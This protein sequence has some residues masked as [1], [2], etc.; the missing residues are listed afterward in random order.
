MK[1]RFTKKLY[2]LVAIVALLFVAIRGTAQ[3]G[4]AMNFSKPSLQYITVPHS[5]SINLGASF[6]MEAMVMYAGAS[7]TIVDKGDYDFL[8]S[9]NANDNGSKMG[10]FNPSTGWVYSTGTVRQGVTTHVAVVGSGGSVTFYIDGVASGGGVA[11]SRQDNQPMNIGR[12]Q[13]TACQCNHFNGNM[14]ELRIWNVVRTPAQIQ[15]GMYTTVPSNSAGL[16]AYYKFDEASGNTAVDATA[17]A[18]NGTLVNGP[19]RATSY[20]RYGS[21]G[22]F[23]YTVPQGIGSVYLRA[24]GAGASASGDCNGFSGGGG[25]YSQSKPM[26]V[27]PGQVITMRVGTAGG[28]AAPGEESYV[29]FASTKKLAAY[30][31]VVRYGGAASTVATFPDL[32]FSYKGGDAGN[33]ISYVNGTAGTITGFGGAGASGSPTGA[34]GNGGSPTPFVYTTAGGTAGAEGGN[35]GGGA[36]QLDCAYSFS[37]S[38]AQ[39]GQNV[40]AG[41]GAPYYNNLYGRAVG[42]MIQM[43]MC[44]LGGT[45]GPSHTVPYPAELSADTIRS[46]DGG[47]G[48]SF[49]WQTSANGTSGWTTIAGATAAYYPLPTPN[50]PPN[51]VFYRRLTATC[52]NTSNV[53]MIRT[54]TIANTQLKGKI[55]GTVVSINNTGVDGIPVEAQKTVSLLGSPITHIYRDTTRNGGKFSFKNVFY[56]DA[57]NNDPGTTQF[58]IKAAYAGHIFSPPVLTSLA[59]TGSDFEVTGLKITDSTVYA[60]SGAVT[61]TCNTCDV[62]VSNAIDS[63]KVA[64]VRAGSPVGISYSG[65]NGPGNYGFT[66]T[67]PGDYV[68][69]PSYRNHTFAPPARTVNVTNGS[70]PNNNFSDN[71]TRT[72]TGTLR[73]GNNQV[74]GSAQLVFTDTV[75]GRQPAFTKTVNTAADGSFSVTLPARKY[76]VRVNTFTPAGAGTDITAFELTTFFNQIIKDSMLVDIDTLPRTFNL[77]YHRSP[78]LQIVNLADTTCGTADYVVFRQNKP[79]TFIIN[80]FEGNPSHGFKVATDTARRINLTTNVHLDNVEQTI[81]RAQVNGADTIA[82]PG[83]EPNIIAPFQKNFRLNYIDKYGRPAPQITRK[84]VVLGIKNDP[85]T[86]TTVSPQIPLMIL[87]DPPG[88]QSSSFWE[89]NQTNET[90]MRMY[91]AKSE[92]NGGYLEVKLGTR[93]QL[94]FVYSTEVSIWGTLNF[95]QTVTGRVNDATE[96]ILTTTNS[97]RYESSNSGYIIGNDGD[98]YI[99]AALNLLYAIA[100]EVKYT[101]PCTLG[102]EAKLAI[103]DSGFATEYAY[104]ESHITGTVIPTLQNFAANAPDSAQRFRALNQ[105]H[106]WEQV[107]ANNAANKAKAKFEVNKSFDGADAPITLSTTTTAT[108]SNTIEYAMEIDRNVA[109]ALGFEIAGIGVSGG[110]NVN[111]KMETGKSTTTTTTNSTTMGYTLDDKDDGDY[112]S[113]DVKR[114]PVYNSP[115]FSLKAGTT[116]C[117]AEPPGQNR[118]GAQ[119]RIP[120]PVQNNVPAN[121]AASFQLFL[122][123]VSQSGEAR[124]YKLTMLPASNPH[125]AIVKIG[126][127][128]ATDLFDFPGIPYAQEQLVTITVEKGAGNVYNYEGLK[129]VMSSACGGSTSIGTITANFANPCSGISLGAPANNFIISAANNNLLPVQMTGYTVANLQSIALEHTSAGGSIFVTDTLILAANITNPT[130]TMVNWRTTNLPDG[131]YDLRLRLDCAGGVVYSQRVTGI[132]DRKAPLVFGEPEPMDDSYV[133]GDI[134]SVTYNESINTNSLNGG[135]VKLRKRSDGT[136]I[137]VQVTGYQNKIVVVPVNPIT[138][139]V[140]ENLQLIVNNIADVYGNVQTAADTSLFV[141]GTTVPGT[142]PAALNLTVTRSSMRENV[143]DSLDFRFNIGTSVNYDRLVNYTVS[144]TAIYGTDYTVR[145]PVGQPAATSFNGIQGKIYILAGQV[146]ATLRIKAI[147]DNILEPDETITVSLAEGDYTPGSVISKTD[148]IKNDDLSKP[149]IIQNG[150]LNICG[151]QTLS[152]STN[153]TIDGQPVFSY[154]WT[155]GG[156]TVGSTQSIN[157]TEAGTYRLTVYIATGF[158]GVSDSLVVTTSA[159]PAP[160]LGADVTVYKSCFGETTNLNSLFNTT[161]LTVSWNTVNTTTAPPGIYRIVASSAGSCNDT[162]FANVILEVATW[163][164][165]QSNDWNTPGNWNINKVPG[166]LTHVIVPGGTPNPCYINT[167][168]AVAASIQVRNGGNVRTVTT[169]SVMVNGKCLTLPPN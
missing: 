148:T 138:S 115:V 162:A 147:G 29:M 17:N 5:S 149:I 166:T 1:P 12:Q 106:V 10:F 83:G 110:F 2:S 153:N 69:T 31:G 26:A 159:L 73:A 20:L 130:S 70:V 58:R 141:V 74:I 140:G 81:L 23:T 164:G 50:N 111:M 122:G 14:D 89:S 91:T 154:Q 21:P 46:I 114:D 42:G 77:I 15:A 39:N 11:A 105:V 51:E 45:I 33:N 76:K 156:T 28:L 18:N 90:A 32:D 165:A 24:W 157:V 107:V 54:Y 116:S 16:V 169:K 129:F 118:D 160:N 22:V 93:F 4:T 44:P 135:Q 38:A 36:S 168:G 67:D 113:V 146:Q 109:I 68:I 134:L 136:L 71:T 163:T 65:D 103:A 151:G 85:G 97:Q 82:L 102:V 57:S 47:G 8:W 40:G 79:R 155:R 143:N 48:S 6:T 43:Y 56:G 80:V 133:A 121:G 60:I 95:A 63:V 132:V 19:T 88:D 150:P 92:A 52:G 41:G 104:T 142:G 131:A 87:H 120:A 7:V 35:G 125:G 75:L 128:P 98:V 66:F 137:P 13:P 112:F 96:A 61:Q 124:D 158:T 99:G 3:L 86:F 94:G 100:R 27:T 167:E 119:L 152:F 101:S 72:I 34:G 145:Y 55:E 78:V 25:A 53:A 161:G 62:V 9:L 127:A 59:G 144:G 117:P 30:G 49:T 64:A 123:N 108:S 37:F 84:A 139:L 126:F